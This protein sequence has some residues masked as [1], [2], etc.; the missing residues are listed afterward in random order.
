MAKTADFGQDDA[1]TFGQGD[2]VAG[3][4]DFGQDDPPAAQRDLPKGVKASDAGG[5]RG[6]VNPKA[7]EADQESD[8]HVAIHDPD[9][10]S[11]VLNTSGGGLSIDDKRTKSPGRILDAD[12]PKATVGSV[13]RD[14]G[15]AVLKV[16]PSAVKGLGDIARLASGDRVGKDFSKAAQ[17]DIDTISKEVGSERSRKQAQRL[18]QDMQDPALNP[19]EVVGDNPGAL[20]D[21]ALPSMGSMILPG[22]AAAAASRV[23]Q[24]GRAAQVA[25]AIEPSVV[26]GRAA[27]AGNAAAVGTTMAQNAADTFTDVKDS[28]GANDQAYT[29]AA[30]TA[31]FTYLAARLTGN[32]AE[33]S[34]ARKMMGQAAKTTERK[35]LAAVGEAAAKGMTKEGTQESVEELGQYTGEQTGKGGEFDANTAG[36]RMAVAGTMGALTGGPVDA[37]IHVSELRKNGENE[38]ADA[39]ERQHLRDTV[40]P[41]EIEAMG[42]AAAHPAFQE[43]YKQY[44][45]AKKPPVEAAARAGMQTGLTELAAAGGITEKAARAIA[46]A[47]ADKPLD[48]VPGFVER[49]ITGM[50]KRGMGQSAPPGQVSQVLQAVRDDAMGAA[51]QLHQ[52]DVKATMDR[53]IAMEQGLPD[54][55]A[56][57]PQKGAAG[58]KTSAKNVSGKA[59]IGAVNDPIVSHPESDAVHQAATSPLNDLTEPSQAQKEAGNYKVGRMTINGMKVSIENPQG[60]VRE[61]V[62][63]DGKSWKTEMKSHYGYFQGTTGADKGHLDVMV[64]PGTPEDW[65]GPMFV[66]DQVDPKTRTFD[67][68]KVVAGANNE[69]D[70]EREYLSNYE[71]GWK[72]IGAIT[73]LPQAPFRAWA[74]SGKV[75]KEPLGD[76]SQPH[77]SSAAAAAPGSKVSP[78]VGAAGNDARAAAAPADAAAKG[79]AANAVQP[80]ADAGVRS[81]DS[82]QF[83]ARALS[84][85]EK[86]AQRLGLPQ[87][88]KK[89]EPIP[90][91]AFIA[92]E[93]GM[94][95]AAMADMGFDR[96]VRVGN[97]TLFAREGK[98]MTLEQ[99]TLK[100]IQ[101]GYL[102]E[103]AS[104]TDTANLIAKSIKSPQYNEE[105]WARKG[106]AEAATR[107]EDHLAAQEGEVDDPF[108][109]TPEELA[110]LG[111]DKASREVQAEF[112]ALVEAAQ[113]E[114]ID[115][116]TILETAF[117]LTQN[118]TDHE[119]RQAAA[120]DLNAAREKR[121]AAPA[122]PRSEQG[123]AAAKPAGAEDGRAP[124]G[125]QGQVN[126]ASSA[127]SRETQQRSD[128]DRALIAARKEV[129]ILKKLRGCLS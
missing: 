81:A 101:D 97:R 109:L 33:G 92:A 6:S 19:A 121:Q 31:P 83:D 71:P 24:A 11:N 105:G 64:K 79:S 117:N 47:A 82:A 90:A 73:K 37:M 17:A 27:V 113:A 43:A 68:H 86:T 127:V 77:Q 65:K 54:P 9:G 44:R 129:S 123:R 26:A 76:I 124:P 25:K 128:A 57:V 74:F 1:I 21:M 55:E 58:A 50:N 16:I 98:G 42:P 34:I 107:F 7:S 84:A 3:A 120:A 104:H 112:R 63:P 114:G 30:I 23:A 22:G 18:S 28:G 48:A 80:A 89:G 100:L 12:I 14:A 15:A 106:E 59:D 108:N 52:P 99:A 125:Q 49:A 96:N 2:P 32:G 102:K 39:L 5:G 119:Y 29:A 69:A 13:A 67:E 126:P 41:V 95:K 60:S 118:G 20:A 35:G 103:G 10:L 53:I 122:G 62:S 78:A 93:G 110:D 8:P 45:T 4:A 94:S 111:Y 72:G 75:L 40:A 116:D 85:R 70:A 115:T 46:E 66:I 88:S 38:A 51:V 36:K 61:G 56:A 91:H 87:T